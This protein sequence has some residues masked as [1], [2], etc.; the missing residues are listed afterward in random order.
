MPGER[1]GAYG[2][3]GSTLYWVKGLKLNILSS[4]VHAIFAWIF[5]AR[6]TIDTDCSAQ[7]C[8]VHWWNMLYLHLTNFAIKYILIYSLP[9]ERVENNRSPDIIFDFKYCWLTSIVLAD[10]GGS[11]TNFDMKICVKNSQVLESSSPL[12][13]LE[14]S[15]C[16]RRILSTKCWWECWDACCF[17]PEQAVSEFDKSTVTLVC[18]FQSA[19]YPVPVRPGPCRLE[20]LAAPSAPGRHCP[21]RTILCH[22]YAPPLILSHWQAL[23][24]RFAQPKQ[25]QPTATVNQP[26]SNFGTAPVQMNAVY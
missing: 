17:E 9:L 8:T 21:L 24:T 10:S 19:R 5:V 26:P 20:S 25:Q 7:W 2:F 14:W 6:V 1:S 4:F 22:C 15:C 13:F 3:Y 11:N 23:Q 16:F 12:T 18:L